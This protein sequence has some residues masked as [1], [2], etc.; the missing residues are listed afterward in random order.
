MRD[1]ISLSSFS[2]NLRSLQ[3]L[4]PYIILL[5]YSYSRLVRSSLAVLKIVGSES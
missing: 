5:R 3:N 4:K 2:L 1:V